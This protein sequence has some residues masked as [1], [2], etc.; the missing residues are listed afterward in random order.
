MSRLERLSLAVYMTLPAT[1]P[2]VIYAASYR[3]GGGEEVA[4]SW[5]KS[6]V[7]IWAQGLEAEEAD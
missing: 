1:S 2:E 4:K 7:R 6:S 5:R 3:M